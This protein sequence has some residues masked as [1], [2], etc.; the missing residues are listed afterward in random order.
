LTAG[1]RG[2]GRDWQWVCLFTIQQQQ[3]SLTD[4]PEKGSRSSHAG[5]LRRCFAAVASHRTPKSRVWR[6]CWL[7]G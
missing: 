5:Q 3:T 6:R 7:F 2:L 1:S 4:W